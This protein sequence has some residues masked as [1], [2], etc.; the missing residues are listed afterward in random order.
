MS[1]TI[2][3]ADD[4]KILKTLGR[5]LRDGGYDVATAATGMG[6]VAAARERPFDVL[7]V[8]F[9]MPDR[10][11]LDVLRELADTVPDAE[12]RPPS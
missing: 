12:R 10:T 8:D 7:L 1:G 5:A 9:L 2:L 6:R 4:E 3:L 11:G